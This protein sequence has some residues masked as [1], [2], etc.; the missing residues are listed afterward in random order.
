MSRHNLHH[1]PG[2][3]P[4]AHNLLRHALQPGDCALDATAGNGH[5]TLLLAQCV[6]AHGHV[7]AFDV[8]PPALAATRARLQQAGLLERATLIADS[9]AHLRQHITAGLKAAVFNLGYLP[10]SDKTVVTQPTST[11][12]ALTQ[13]LDLLLPGGVLVVVI[14]HGHS[15]GEEER[16][17]VE[18][19]CAALDSQYAVAVR[20][21]LV[22]QSGPPPYV[23]AVEK[24]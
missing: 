19:W 24:R 3:L 18:H 11:V 4:F 8:Q 5:D 2:I 7:Y 17:A 20:Y 15:G 22:N 13:A 9:H 23:L 16:Q 10:G 14:Y 12:S 6:G 1:L 21:Q